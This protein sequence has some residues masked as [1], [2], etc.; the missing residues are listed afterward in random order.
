MLILGFQPFLPIKNPGKPHVQKNQARDYFDFSTF[1]TNLRDVTINELK[2]L[3]SEICV[4]LS[5]R[6]DLHNAH[7]YRPSAEQC[8]Q[9]HAPLT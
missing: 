1:Q 6:H 8:C 7:A 2:V 5:L 3:S 9:I 4:L